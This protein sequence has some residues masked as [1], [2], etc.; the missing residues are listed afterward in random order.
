VTENYKLII[1][2]GLIIITFLILILLPGIRANINENT[3]NLFAKVRGEILPDTNIVLINITNEDIEQIGPWP[4]KRSYYALLI[5]E[6]SK[7][8]VKKIGL[9]IFLSSRFVTQT[10]YDNLLKKEIENSGV[11]V[12]GSVTGKII[13]SDNKF[14]TDSLSFPSPKLLNENLTTGHLNYIKDEGIV[15]PLTISQRSEDEKAFSVQL[16]DTILMDNDITVNFISSW[17][18]F[19]RYSAVDFSKLVYSNSNEL[20]NFVNKIVIIGLS[21][22]QIAPSIETV[23]DDEMPGVALHAFALDNILNSRFI[24]TNYETVSGILFFLILL[25]MIF[26]QN[27]RRFGFLKFYLLPLTILLSLSFILLEYFYIRLMFSFFIIPFIVLFITDLIIHLKKEKE[28]LYGALNEA[29]VLKSLLN[30]KESELLHLQNELESDG[31]ESGI[32]HEKIKSLKSDI[33]KLKESGE[34]RAEAVLKESKQ[35]E[36]FYGIIYRSKI[37]AEVVDLIKKAAPTDTTVLIIGESGTGKE[38][39][40]NAIHSLSGRKDKNFVAVNCG[41]LT[42][43]LL[44]SELFGHVRG[45]FTGASADKLGRFETADKGTILLDEIAETS[46]NFQV[47]MLRVLQ[48]GEIE[49]VGSSKQHKVDVRVIAATNKE[50]EPAV[51]EKIFREDLY[52]RLNVF[53]IILPPLR[54]RKEDIDTLTTFFLKRES[55]SFVISKAAI[56]ALNEYVWKG[57]V[58]ELESVIKRA[59]IFA[60]AEKRNMIQLSDLP[61]ELVKETKYNFENLVLESLRN[62]NFSH[63]SITDTA[64]ELGNVN[65]TMIAENFRGTAFKVFVECNFDL[66]GAVEAIAQTN[67]SDVKDKVKNKIQTFLKN[68][69]DDIVSS[70]NKDFELFRNK[71]S[72]KYKNLPVKFHHYL[73]EVIKWKLNK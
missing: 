42:E 19:I 7:L 59:V 17:K 30:K 61:K 49:K 57:N 55:E 50:L 37:M 66:D 27:K 53:K 26:Y 25:V 8:G 70:G 39:A 60:R 45:A 18:K 64:K 5:H 1:K 31:N 20:K 71:F 63:S 11:V 47:K 48:S 16:A 22:T 28:I 73:D 32:L 2:T 62:K 35:P 67:D 3:G 52:Y 41:A 36:N 14:Y 6:L 43:S 56:L 23:F 54:E 51:K 65:R 24:R 4:I 21:D 13:R 12:L 38:L 68:I 58:R 72:S 10:I 46:E 33:E 69:E 9:E 29:E 44:E 40:A 34:D 15:I